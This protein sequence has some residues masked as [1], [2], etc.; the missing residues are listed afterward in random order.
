MVVKMTPLK[1]PLIAKTNIISKTNIAL[2]YNAWT[3][4]DKT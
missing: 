4:D 3:S 2:E 1:G